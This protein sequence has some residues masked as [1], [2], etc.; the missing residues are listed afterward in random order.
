MNVS[1]AEVINRQDGATVSNAGGAPITVTISNDAGDEQTIVV[2][3]GG[4]VVWV[5]PEGW[6][7]ATFQSPGHT[8]LHREIE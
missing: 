4:S 1:P 2:P 8:E 7:E 3:A 5:P 6:T